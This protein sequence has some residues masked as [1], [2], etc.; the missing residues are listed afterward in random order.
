MTPE[1]KIHRRTVAELRAT[2]RRLGYERGTEP[3]F[4]CPNESKV[5]A[6][7]RSK[8]AALG[9]SNGVPDL[10]IVHPVTFEGSIFPGLALEL[11]SATGRASAA[12][13]RWLGTWQSA[14]FL[15][16]VT[17]GR[18]QTRDALL[19]CGL[20]DRVQWERFR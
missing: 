9:L 20:I 5:P 17:R 3:F 8:L 2:F 10:I 15:A 13:V 11:K 14:G 6:R 16:M 19:A 4:H 7:Y 18:D 12:Q 1:E